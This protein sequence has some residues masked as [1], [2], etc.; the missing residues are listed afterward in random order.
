MSGTKLANQGVYETAN[1]DFLSKKANFA[2]FQCKEKISALVA[3]PTSPI[4][5]ALESGV[6]VKKRNC[7][8]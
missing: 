1:P 5:P 6:I 2:G 4:D 7:C 8:G 3:A